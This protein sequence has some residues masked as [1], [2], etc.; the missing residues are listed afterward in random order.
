MSGDGIGRTLE[1][2]LFLSPDPMSAAELAEAIDGHVVALAEPAEI[3]A[4][5]LGAWG[6]DE[7]VV[8]VPSPS[9]V[10]EVEPASPTAA[11]AG[12]GTPVAERA[13]ALAAEDVAAAVAGWA[14]DARP[15]AVL[16]PSTAWGREMASRMAARMRAGLTGDAIDLE[17]G[18]RGRL[19]AWKPAFGGAL[20]AAITASSP[21]QMATVRAG[22]LDPPEPRAPFAPAVESHEVEVRGLVERRGLQRDDNL[23]DL[24]SAHR[25]VAVGTGVHPDEYGEL[26]PLLEV[27]GAE[28]AATR[29]VTDKGWLPRARQV[30]ITGR[31]IAPQLFVSIGASGK[32]NH[33][34]GFRSAGTVLAVNTDPSAPIFQFCDIGMVGDWHGIVPLLT[35]AVRRE[36]TGS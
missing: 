7:V 15:W 24:A 34:V 30:G 36:V 25:V 18:A 5:R 33:S 35:D 14:E 32:F 9:E 3:D 16:A 19:V 6:A 1:A 2:L 4:A 12:S 20:V 10:S 27:L 17:V 11:M 28:L 22:V 31:S 8:L 26:E 23:D 13:G 21:V 29:K